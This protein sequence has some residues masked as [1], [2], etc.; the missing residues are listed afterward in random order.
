[1]NIPKIALRL[2]KFKNLVATAAAFTVFSAPC[3]SL[4][5]LLTQ[6]SLNFK[7][8]SGKL[9]L[10]VVAG[11]LTQSFHVVVSLFNATEKTH[12]FP[13]LTQ[14]Y[15]RHQLDKPLKFVY[16]KEMEK[17]LLL[18]RHLRT[19]NNNLNDIS[20]S[21]QELLAKLYVRSQA[22]ATELAMWQNKTNQSSSPLNK[23]Q[24]ERYTKQGM[25]LDKIT[26][27]MNIPALA[28]MLAPAIKEEVLRV[29][30]LENIHLNINVWHSCT[31]R[32]TNANWRLEGVFSNQAKF[33][34]QNG[35]QLKDKDYRG[36]TRLFK[37][38]KNEFL[39][40]LL[41]ILAAHPMSTN[42]TRIQDNFTLYKKDDNF[43]HTYSKKCE[44]LVKKTQSV[45]RQQEIIKETEASSLSSLPSSTHS[46]A[47]ELEN[48][49]AQAAAKVE[50]QLLETEVKLNKYVEYIPI[51]FADKWEALKTG[52]YLVQEHKDT[53]DKFELIDFMISFEGSLGAL[54]PADRSITRLPTTPKNY[55]EQAKQL[56]GD[57]LDLCIAQLEDYK[58][59]IGEAHLKEL[60]VHKR[61]QTAKRGK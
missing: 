50:K 26:S 57:N 14:N 9:V 38:E 59:K 20:P 24:F 2:D 53:L 19:E 8:D 12:Y 5:L 44:A 4:Y 40:E 49:K 11:I 25:L 36:I 7:E 27:L 52:Y 43:Y 34:L 47:Q 61:Y 42:W 55:Q 29:Q 37:Q 13:W 10:M 23:E 32:D 60:T 6:T 31:K 30:R 18:I 39:S 28:K 22:K 51:H 17:A 33:L 46:L 45:E 56:L 21:Q 58:E 48:N 1:M 16:K 54:V 41:N 3:W 35:Y 15:W